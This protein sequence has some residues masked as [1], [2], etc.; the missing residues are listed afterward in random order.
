VNLQKAPQPPKRRVL[1]RD[2]GEM[3]A[4]SSLAARIY[5]QTLTDPAGDCPLDGRGFGFESSAGFI[6]SRHL[7]LALPVKL[8]AVLCI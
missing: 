5:R 1:P 6:R 3:A 4:R 7:P 2:Q 8:R